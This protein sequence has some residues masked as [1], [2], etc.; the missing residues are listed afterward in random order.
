MKQLPLMV[1]FF[2]NYKM[3][4]KGYVARPTD[5][6]EQHTPTENN[7][8]LYVKQGLANGALL[9]HFVHSISE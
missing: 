9:I 7:I 6:Y 5:D 2:L 4:V 8:V 1:I 3:M